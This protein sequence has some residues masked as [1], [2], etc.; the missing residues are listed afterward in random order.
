[1]IGLCTYSSLIGEFSGLHESFNNATVFTKNIKY[2]IMNND[3]T[4]FESVM[5]CLH[6]TSQA[7]DI[8]VVNICQS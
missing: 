6:T 8:G 5:A 4:M 2:V 7:P 1:M 3:H